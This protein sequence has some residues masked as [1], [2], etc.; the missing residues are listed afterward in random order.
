MRTKIYTLLVA[1][2]VTLCLFP[3]CSSSKKASKPSSEMAKS[4]M[5]RKNDLFSCYQ[6]FTSAEEKKVTRSFMGFIEVDDLGT[7]TEARIDKSNFVQK[8][9]NQCIIDVVSSIHFHHLKSGRKQ[10]LV[11]FPQGIKASDL[12]NGIGED[13]QDDVLYETL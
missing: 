4:L 2:I 13:Y 7:V 5:G 11:T 1:C 8:E 12:S 10:V 6:R 3:A 9:A